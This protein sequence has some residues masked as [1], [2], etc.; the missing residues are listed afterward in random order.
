MTVRITRRRSPDQTMLQI[1]GRLRW[2][3][4]DELAREYAVSEDPLVL[5]LSNLQSADPTG[6]EA[7]R[8]LVALGAEVRGASPYLRLLLERVRY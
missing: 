8:E 1:D 7:L 4:L 3:D 2:D 5:E 6:V